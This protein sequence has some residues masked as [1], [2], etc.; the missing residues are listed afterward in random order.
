M[1]ANFARFEAVPIKLIFLLFHYENFL[2]ILFKLFFFLNFKGRKK[3]AGR[4]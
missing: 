3:M 4:E 2:D 1:T